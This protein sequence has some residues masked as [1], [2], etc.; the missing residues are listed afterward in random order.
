M[1]GEARKAIHVMHRLVAVLLG[2]YLLLL[3]RKLWQQPDVRLHFFAGLLMV[4]FAIQFALG[5]ANVYW[6]LPLPVA[7]AHNFGGACLFITMIGLN[8]VL[9][10]R[11]S[12]VSYE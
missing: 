11:R 10:S 9:F 1:D 7:V 6:H 12:R 3:A 5:L 2:I 4:L 8:Y